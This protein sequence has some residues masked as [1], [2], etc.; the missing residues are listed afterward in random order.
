MKDLA[1]QN[2]MSLAT[3]KILGPSLRFGMMDV[4]EGGREI[5]DFSLRSNF[6]Y[7]A[8]L[9]KCALVTGKNQV[10]LSS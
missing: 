5:Q 1:R 2:T 6:K 9:K 3:L 7:S 4:L 8:E 10:F